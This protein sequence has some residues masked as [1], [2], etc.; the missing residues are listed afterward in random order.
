MPSALANAAAGSIR[1]SNGP[2]QRC[3]ASAKSSFRKTSSNGEVDMG[4]PSGFVIG[5][6]DTISSMNTKYTKS[7]LSPIVAKSTSFS[8][9]CR[10]L[11]L[12]P[13]GG[14]A[15]HIKKV[16]ESLGLST[17][18]FLGRAAGFGKVSRHR[19]PPNERL[20]LLTPD[21]FR[22]SG[23]ILRKSLIE[24]GRKEECEECGQKPSW[25]GKSLVLTPD[26]KNGKAWDNRPENLRMLC[27]NCH[28][29]TETFAGR[30]KEK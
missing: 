29:Q 25:N 22:V 19:V 13:H 28:S 9:V 8:Q 30:N 17:K 18:H 14:T 16:I 21:H 10:E 3:P 2:A 4:T 15:N 1:D 7:Q 23:K 26:H 12:Q 5:K 20:V 24:S 11:S 27:P 6:C